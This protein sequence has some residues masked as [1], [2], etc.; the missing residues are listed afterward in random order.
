MM[1]G[2]T[3]DPAGPMPEENAMR[4]LLPT[5][6]IACLLIASPAAAVILLSDDRE[7]YVFAYVCIDD[8]VPVGGSETPSAP[9][10]PFDATVVGAGSGYSA[11]QASEVGP[12][13]ILGQ[14]SA[15]GWIDGDARSTLDVEFEVT[16]PT[17]IVFDATL[18]AYGP[19]FNGDA[20]ALARL[21]E[22]GGANLFQESACGWCGGVEDVQGVHVETVLAPGTYALS[23]HAV[24]AEYGYDASYD[25]SL[26][27]L[28]EPSS[29]LLMGIALLTALRPHQRNQ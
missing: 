10:A 25:F 6:V 17:A 5:F 11:F 4:L 23:V 15:A 28:P 7:V 8:C 22:V 16:T 3:R 27:F 12:D 21:D 26:S 29:G 2:G 9:F 20:G 18:T 1:A 13:L 19:D 14:G 24:S